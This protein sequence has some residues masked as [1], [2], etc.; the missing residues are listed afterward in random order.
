MKSETDW[1]MVSNP[2]SQTVYLIKFIEY[3][4]VLDRIFQPILSQGWYQKTIYRISQSYFKTTND[5]EHPMT[6]DR[7]S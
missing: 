4:I 1:L 6:T 5:S 3:P 7:C 2:I